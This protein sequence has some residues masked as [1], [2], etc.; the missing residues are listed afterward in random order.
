MMERFRQ[1]A[2][3]EQMILGAGA[4]LAFLIVGWSFIWTPL[5]NTVDE[6]RESVGDQSRLMVDLKRAASL[7]SS[8]SAVA[9]GGA[10]ELPLIVEQTARPLGI[11]SSFTTARSEAGNASYRVSFQNTSYALLIDWLVTLDR[12]YGVR[13]GEVRLQPGTHGPGFVNGAVMLS[14]N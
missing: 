4:A 14:R 9:G 10:D 12:D 6:L 8:A 11:A 3:R 1:L 5:V 2:P 13:A 7:P